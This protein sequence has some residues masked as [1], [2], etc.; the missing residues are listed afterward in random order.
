MRIVI[1]ALVVFS[2]ILWIGY[3]VFLLPEQIAYRELQATIREKEARIAQIKIRLAQPIINTAAD[4]TPLVEYHEP[5]LLDILMQSIR[6][7]G[8]TIRELQPLKP[9]S[10]SGVTVLPVSLLLIGQYDAFRYFVDAITNYPI[11][12]ASFRVHAD[13]S[14]DLL[15]TLQCLLFYSPFTQPKAVALYQVRNPFQF[16]PLLLDLPSKTIPPHPIRTLGYVTFNHETRILVLQSNGQTVDM[17]LNQLPRNLY[18]NSNN[19][20]LRMDHIDP[21]AIVE[22][23]GTSKSSGQISFA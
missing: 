4:P 23:S 6:E 9:Q 7:S 3:D 10:M 2:I 17:L 14:G 8:L 1:V 13:E 16:A 20:N 15:I 5:Q 11:T 21:R 19:K 18:E 12:L 22:S